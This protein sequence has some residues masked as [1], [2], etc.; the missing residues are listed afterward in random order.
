VRR[1]IAPITVP[2]HRIGTTMIDRT[3][4]MSSVALML[5]SDG[6]VTASGMNTVSPESKARLSS[7]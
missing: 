5:L 1:K 6:S 4:R 2:C 3:L 7:G